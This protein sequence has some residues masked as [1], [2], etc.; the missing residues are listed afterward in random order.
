MLPNTLF[1]HLLPLP[2]VTLPPHT[3][4]ALHIFEPRYRKMV[5]VILK[6]DRLLGLP[7]LKPGW[8][9][10][11]Y[12]APSIYQTMGIGKVVDHE[13]L[14]NGNYNIWLSGLTR[15]RI[16]HEVQQKPFRVAKVETLADVQ[17]SWKSNAISQARQTLTDLA[18][19]LAI[20]HPAW[21]EQIHKVL[22][23]HV[24]PGALADALGTLT[25]R[26]IYTRQS[27]IT[28][29][30][31]LRRLQYAIIQIRMRL[32]EEALKSRDSVIP[33]TFLDE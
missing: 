27:F 29:T 31:L 24:Y 12:E 32:D 8:E 14:E 3:L 19:R 16:I 23:D 26:D 13:K 33:E 17:R 10:R 11:Y 15:A 7:V 5:E 6:G 25:A 22:E 4:L 30:D 18:R 9:H 1:V 21:R 28:E 2:N 20:Q